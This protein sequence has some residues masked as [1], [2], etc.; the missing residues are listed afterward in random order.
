MGMVIVRL[1][2]WLPAASLVPLVL[3]P[4]LTDEDGTQPSPVTMETPAVPDVATGQVG[5][6]TMKKRGSLKA[7]AWE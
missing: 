1:M 6:T 5:P 3:Q 2:A 4:P 7:V